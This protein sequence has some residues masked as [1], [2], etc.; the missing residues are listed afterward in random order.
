MLDV[1]VYI[2]QALETP[3][4]GKNTISSKSHGPAEAALSSFTKGRKENESPSLADVSPVWKSLHILALSFFL[5]QRKSIEA[6]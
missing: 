1:R 3:W 5:W 4:P 6:P 2:L